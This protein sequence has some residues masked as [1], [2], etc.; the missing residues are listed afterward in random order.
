MSDFPVQVSPIQDGENCWKDPRSFLALLRRLLKVVIPDELFGKI[1]SSPV[2]PP[3]ER[4]D[5]VWEKRSA[6][7]EP[8][9][10]FRKFGG[11]FVPVWPTSPGAFIIGFTGDP[12]SI[13][14]PFAVC[15]GLN[16]TPD[17][18]HLMCKSGTTTLGTSGGINASGAITV[19]LS[20]GLMQYVG[21]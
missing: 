20:Y 16:G 21:Y 3:A 13:S 18:R 10:F 15:D 6:N 12:A 4:T 17:L 11:Q 2:P 5:W 9:G 8:L 19:S 14:A 7:G 1:W